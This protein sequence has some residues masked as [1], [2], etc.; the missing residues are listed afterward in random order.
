MKVDVH[1][2]SHSAAAAH[3]ANRQVQTRRKK[4][5]WQAWHDVNPGLRRTCLSALLASCFIDPALANPTGPQVVHGQASFSQNGNVLSIVNSPNA[6]INWQNFSINPN[7]IT[8][9]LQQGADSSVLNRIVGQNPSQILGALQ[10]NGKVFLINPNGVVFGQGARV[11]VNG[12]VASSLAL[13]NADF[14][15]GRGNF[16]DA[17]GALAGKVENHGNITT[18][19]GGQVFLLAPNVENSGIITAPNGDVIL[20]AGHTVQLVD[21]RHPEVRVV[22]SSPESTA[23]NLGQVVSQAGR[24]GNYGALVRQKGVLNADSAVIGANGQVLLKASRDT[25]LE[26]GSRTSALAAGQGGQVT[27]LGERVGLLG[28]ATVDVSG[29]LGGGTALVGGDYQGKNPQLPNAQFT[30][31]SPQASI[32]ADATQHGNG[33]KVVLWADHGTQAHGTVTAQGGLQG[34]NGGLV[35]TS[36]KQVLDVA[37]ASINAAARSHSGKNGSWL[38]DPSDITVVHGSIG[39]LSSGVFDPG[40]SSSIGDT[41]IN[42]TLSGGT[43]VTLQ[44]SSGTGGAGL[45]T[46]NGSSDAGGAVAIINRGGGDRSLTL[47]TSGVININSGATIAGQSGDPLSVNLQG[48]SLNL[49]GSIDN[50]GGATILSGDA[51][52]LGTLKNGTLS[53]ANSI[54]SNSGTFDNVTV[55]GT[56]TLGSSSNL[57][58]DNNLTLANAGVLNLGNSTVYFQSPGTVQLASTGSSTVNLAGGTLLAGYLVNGQTLQ[59]DAGVTLQGYGTVSDS[60]LSVLRNAGQIVSNTGGQT[61]NLMVSN[62]TND[63]ALKADSGTLTVGHISWNNN[64]TMSVGA[65]GTLNLDFDSTVAGLGSVTRSGGVVNFNGILDNSNNTLDV[66]GSGP[67]GSGG[68]TLLGGTIMGGTILSSDST[69]FN[70]NGAAKVDGVTLSGN[71]ASSGSLTIKNGITL[72]NSASIDLGNGSNWFFEGSGAQHIATSGAA[73]LNLAGASL[74]AGSGT[75]GQILHVDSGVTI[76]GHGGI[77]QSST[78][79]LSVAGIIN[80]NASG[81]ML[82][83]NVNTLNNSGKLEAQAGIL[84]IAPQAWSN[85]GTLE[86]SGSG[87]MNLNFD[88]T[89][90]GLGSVTRSGGAVNFNGVL[91]N[92]AATLDI[93]GAGI[94]GAG[95]LTSFGGAIKGGTV[96]SSDSTH[97]QA[98]GNGTL[99]GVT[100]AGNLGVNGAIFIKNG[101]TLDV[102]AHIG[103]GN[104]LVYFDSPG[105]QHIATPDMATLDMAGATLIAGHGVTGQTLQIDNGVTVQGHG[106]I[107]QSNPATLLNHGA[108]VANDNSQFLNL[109]LASISNNG[110]MHAAAGTLSVT[111]LLANDGLIDTGPNAIFNTN[112]ANLVNNSSGL[113]SGTGTIDLGVGTLTNNGKLHPGSN[114]QIGMLK[115]DGKFVAGATSEMHFDVGPNATTHDRLDITG[116]ATLAG[117]LNVGTV[118]SYTPANGDQYPLLSYSGSATGTFGTINSPAFVGATPDYANSGSFI[119]RMPAGSLL[120]IWNFDG[121]GNWDDPSKWSLGHVPTANEE[122]QVPDYSTQFTVNIASS[123]LNVKSVVFLGNDHLGLSGGVFNVAQTSNLSSGFLDISGTGVFNAGGNVSVMGLNL[124]GSGTLNLHPGSTLSVFDYMQSG[125]VINGVANVVI[126]NSFQRTGGGFDSAITELDINHTAGNLTPGAISIDGFLKLRA[127][128]GNIL[129]DQQLASNNVGV[130]LNASQGAVINA[131]GSISAPVLGVTAQNGIGHGTPL[132]TQV[133]M[134]QAGNTGSGD[135]AINNSGAALSLTDVGMLGFAVKQQGGGAISINHNSAQPLEVNGL[136]QSSSGTINLNAPALVFDNTANAK[137]DGGD[138]NVLLHA[139]GPGGIV[140]PAAASVEING[141]GANPTQIT[142]RTDFLTLAGSLN[143]GAVAG[144]GR[145]EISPNSDLAL[146]VETNPVAGHL[147]LSPLA[148][149]NI[150]GGVLDLGNSSGSHG[151]TFS[152]PLSLSGVRS[153]FVN[154]D[155]PIAV[156]AGLSVSAAGGLMVLRPG[157]STLAVGSNGTLAATNILVPAAGSLDFSQAGAG[158][159]GMPGGS[160]FLL[161]D[162][163]Q[164][165]PNAPINVGSGNVDLAT[166][167]AGRA[168]DIVATANQMSSSL[169]LAAGEL[170]EISAGRLTIGSSSTGLGSGHLSV[171]A[172]LTSHASVNQLILGA[173]CNNG[174]NCGDVSQSAGAVITAPNLVVAGNGVQLNLASN[175]VDNLAANVSA[176]GNGIAFANGRAL[177]IGVA[178]NGLNAPDQDIALTLDSGFGLTLGEEVLAGTGS[179]LLQSDLLQTGNAGVVA[180]GVDIFPSTANRPITVGSAT[181]NSTP[182]LAISD[183]HRFATPNLVIGSTAQSVPPGDIY[184]AGISVGGIGSADRNALTNRIDLIGAGDIAQGGSIN[185][186]ELGIRAGGSVNLSGANQVLHLAGSSNGD[187][188]FNSAAGIELLNL[189]ALGNAPAA[190]GVNAVGG[191]LSITGSGGDVLVVGNLGGNAITLSAS[192]ALGG[193]GLISGTSLQANSGSGMNLKT[194]VT[195]LAADNSTSGDIVI[196]NAVPVTVNAVSQNGSGNITIDNT[197]G[198]IVNGPVSSVSG[199][200]NFLAR[201]P[202]TVNGSIS[203]SAGGAITLEAG[204]TGNP[205]DVLT[206]NSGASVTTSGALTLRAGGAIDVEQGSTLSPQAQRLPEQNATLPSLDSCIGNP[207]LPRCNEVLPSFDSCLAAPGTAGCSVVLPSLA[208]CTINPSIAGCSVVLPPLDVCTA[209]PATPGCS[210]VLPPLDVC[211]VDPTTPGCSVVL[212]PIDVCTANP[213]TPGCS[214]VLPPLDVCIANPATPG[215]SVVLPPL[216]VCTANPA[217]PGCSVVLPPIDVC[218]ANPGT[219]G[220]SVVLPPIDVCTANP[221]TPGCSVVLPPIDVCTAN[222]ATPGCSIVLPPIDVCTANP[223]TPGCNVVLPPIDVCTANPA[224]PGCS[225]VLPPIDVCTANP[226]T[227]GC[228]V[229]LPPLDICTANPATPGCSVVLPPLDICTSA[230]ATPGCNVVLPPIDICTTAPATPGCSVVLPPI[231]ICTTA[232][233]TPGCS[234]VLP[235]IDICTTAPATPGCSVVLPPIDICTSA[236]TTPG[237]S[238][239]LPPIDICTTAP[240]TPGCAVVLPPLDACV[241]TPS[242]PGCSAVLPMVIDCL[243]NPAAPGCQVVGNPGNSS[244]VTQDLNEALNNTIEVVTQ[245]AAPKPVAP[246]VTLTALAP[247]PAAASP[248]PESTAP[249]PAPAPAPTASVPDEKAPANPPPD[250]KAQDSTAQETK[251]ADSRPGEAKQDEKK[252]DQ[253]DEKKEEKKDDKKND[254]AKDEKKEAVK[255]EEPVKKLYCN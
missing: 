71:L 105:I 83:L 25:L 23:L 4:S 81:Q 210:A 6:I 224:T 109:N 110:R 58:I 240:I 18:P 93:G 189:P 251:P 72:S 232:P 134:L 227:P 215:C 153:L 197:G 235:P 55:A 242:L 112:G 124:S 187:F 241:D 129:V 74:F 231:D 116:T 228:N 223:A 46:I 220:C 253:K 209:D 77:H 139:S 161:A 20:A 78:A 147:S 76:A 111:G 194:H 188:T 173:G 246:P 65:S 13:S 176:G 200:I 221:A 38:L 166:S 156:N 196:T 171:K 211:T 53:T 16:G 1:Q 85:S 95:G 120:N 148:L 247:P 142:L 191:N 67:F 144:S 66:G 90:S 150:H 48:S 252:A 114:A 206:I 33:G 84:N 37:G 205:G 73:T 102:G 226:A 138:G 158:S 133:G 152:D 244:G 31:F 47:I 233:A 106:S 44:T 143:A 61:L 12:L 22:L 34:G 192:A 62:I 165:G 32:M 179:V 207:G 39:G 28:N 30:Y 75:T 163:M 5:N 217:T 15:A 122:V 89:T 17:S 130:A 94:F 199:D 126:A 250:S 162:H 52:L 97:L 104:S 96:L 100:L 204:S 184:V 10:S 36:G 229:V 212:P 103:L 113:L 146:V 236:P 136:V 238:V 222:P 140:I 239:V 70:G 41:Q 225:V 92:S 101:L 123:T 26:Q 248:A 9:F 216:D 63:G 51:T 56:V 19:N 151:I 54:T 88:T 125:G 183:L 141:S 145:V 185:V 208:S 219:P 24:I 254:A 21:A 213:A 11:D 180:G 29:D 64:G 86:V 218:T 27:L 172:P 249:A 7:E 155:H 186:N 234:V 99:D 118:D 107:I 42:S 164:F 243:T 57:F 193:T 154:S 168:I 132:D 170:S 149:N 137:V 157:A 117:T 237:C 203:S 60:S 69:V 121:S 177:N 3:P 87:V 135:I 169:E 82:N 201:S 108:L 160:V 50:A 98:V 80:A 127:T 182:C 181:C 2:R 14:L 119:F 167:S 190:N 91:D 128:N 43:D 175:Q 159:I 214:V 174:S 202:L 195:S 131:G 230:P 255:K 59:I 245:V 40:T 178:G 45:I 68:L 49:A 8:R 79:D 115:I 198:V 35:E